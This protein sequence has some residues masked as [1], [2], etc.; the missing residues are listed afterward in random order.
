MEWKVKYIYICF[1]WNICSKYCLWTLNTFFIETCAC[2]IEIKCKFQNPVTTKV[3]Y[4]LEKV[5][6]LIYSEKNI[7]VW[8][9]QECMTRR[10][11]C[12]LTLLDMNEISNDFSC[13]FGW[14]R[15]RQPSAY[16]ELST[17]TLSVDLCLNVSCKGLLAP[18]RRLLRWFIREYLPH[19]D[20]T[21]EIKYLGKPKLAPQRLIQ[22]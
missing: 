14:W 19:T 8:L 4:V 15:W 22:S 3:T 2:Y 5:L 20:G 1:I 18:I 7:L 17:A 9:V 16:R 21:E 12:R 6:L 11:L 10:K 13:R